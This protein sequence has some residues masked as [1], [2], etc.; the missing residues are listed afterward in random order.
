MTQA[1]IGLGG[2]GASSG[3]TFNQTRGIE[4]GRRQA[5]GGSSRS[6]SKMHKWLDMSDTE[7]QASFP[8]KYPDVEPNV[9]IYA[10]LLG[11]SNPL[12]KQSVAESPT[13][14]SSS[15]SSIT[16]ASSNTSNESVDSQIS[17]LLEEGLTQLEEGLTQFSNGV[18]SAWGG[19]GRALTDILGSQ[20]NPLSDAE[21]GPS[22]HPLSK[23]QKH[24]LAVEGCPSPSYF[25]V[26]SS[27]SGSNGSETANSSGSGSSP[28][29]K[30]VRFAPVTV[31]LEGLKKFLK[32]KFQWG[33]NA[34]VS[35][36]VACS[37]NRNHEAFLTDYVMDQVF[38]EISQSKTSREAAKKVAEYNFDL[39][40]TNASLTNQKE[41]LQ[42]K[43]K[44]LNPQHQKRIS[45]QNLGDLQRLRSLVE[46]NVTNSLVLEKKFQF[47]T[48]CFE[49]LK[50]RG[51]WRGEVTR[52]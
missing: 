28:V 5:Q 49:N 18:G 44:T 48:L 3:G 46:E 37:V 1:N 36:D 32:E 31:D 2:R 43:I 41:S 52:F 33:Q 17:G 42:A 38:G 20:F 35:R 6:A 47:A 22:G 23:N 12:V 24:W 29:E 10:Q 7:G 15:A 14:S 8:H 30:R 25:G 16:S 4:S 40:K 26:S 13:G 27:K 34:P 9:S 39:K 19:V 45:Q 21:N 51:H 11:F 50:S